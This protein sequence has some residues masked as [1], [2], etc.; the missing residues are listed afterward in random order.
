M[1]LAAIVCAI[2]LC[3]L[4]P[5]MSHATAQ[6][7]DFDPQ[8]RVT[9]ALAAI[10]PV[11][12]HRDRLD[13]VAIE[14][15]ARAL[16][17]GARDEVDLMP[18]YQALVSYLEDNHSQVEYPPGLMDRWRERYGTRRMLPNPPPGPPPPTL[19][20]RDRTE[21]EVRTTPLGAARAGVIIVPSARYEPPPSTF[22]S[23][24][25]AGVRGIQDEV[26]GYVV[27]LRGNTGG[28]LFPMVVGLSDLIGDNRRVVYVRPDGSEMSASLTDGAMHALVEDGEEILLDRIEAWVPAPGVDLR[29]VAVLMDG[30]TASSGEG[31]ALALIGR[32]RVRTFGEQT[33]GLASANQ[34]I[35]L[36]DGTILLITT[37]LMT[38]QRRRTYPE[39]IVPDEPIAPTEDG[40]AVQAAA[41]VWLAT[42]DGCS[43]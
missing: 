27:D 4:C 22:G 26:C 1:R 30:A 6:T 24:L 15:R 5:G 42:Q 36:S 43:S 41:E 37:A 29:P 33:A 31:A 13:W 28:A 38:D 2:C 9:E 17:E 19:R 23:R 20:F 25:H 18:A 32:D 12:Y 21:P 16:A 11:A 14:A 40:D 35:A 8:A 34:E 3:A 7:S 10:R 39:G